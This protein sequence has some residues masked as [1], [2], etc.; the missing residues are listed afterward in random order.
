LGSVRSAGISARKIV[1][2]WTNGN[3]VRERFWVYWENPFSDDEISNLSFIYKF[4]VIF[5][6][7][8]FWK[9]K[10]M[11]HILEFGSKR[12]DWNRKM[13]KV[14][15]YLIS[16]VLL[17][18]VG[19][20]VWWLVDSW[21]HLAT[22]DDVESMIYF[23]TISL[24]LIFLLLEAFKIFWDRNCFHLL[25]FVFMACFTTFCNLLISFKSNWYFFGTIIVQT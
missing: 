24:N 7:E 6:K 18:Q 21:G 19:V 9:R 5:G 15:P 11:T 22:M 13:E 2:I 14:A 16:I 17:L 1:S 4:I 8:I 23:I 25:L 10:K 3:K 12:R 20:F